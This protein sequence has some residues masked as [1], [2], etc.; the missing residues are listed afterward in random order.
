MN[1]IK[2]II[3]RINTG[4]EKFV[5]AGIYS[6]IQCNMLIIEHLEIAP[7]ELENYKNYPKLKKFYDFLLREYEK[8]VTK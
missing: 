5:D 1:E 7:D 3:Q 8:E 2:E 6:D 4:L